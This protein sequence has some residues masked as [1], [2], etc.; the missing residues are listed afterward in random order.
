MQFGSMGAMLTVLG[1][2][3]VLAVLLDNPVPPPPKSE[4]HR[5]EGRLIK[6]DALGENQRG[7]PYALR[8]RLDDGSKRT[9]Y[10][11]SLD[12]DIVEVLNGFKYSRI[13]IHKPPI[14]LSYD[15]DRMT[16]ESGTDFR[17]FDISVAGI[18]LATYEG[19]VKNRST[20][21]GWSFAIFALVLTEGLLF[22]RIAYK[23]RNYQ[24]DDWV[25]RVPS[26]KGRRGYQRLRLHRVF[27]PVDRWFG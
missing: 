13:S 2:W 9:Y 1:G 22:L 14:L 18:T 15:P 17:V 19:A 16:S 5:S 21:P 4:L 24:P 20:F 12:G 11:D 23:R 27:G 7:G 26:G 8:F 6:L 25:N 10:F 3:L